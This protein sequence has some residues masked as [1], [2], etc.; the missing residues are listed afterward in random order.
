MASLLSV[1][2]TL[3]TSGLSPG[4][5]SVPQALPMLPAEML[6]KMPQARSAASAGW[7]ISLPPGPPHD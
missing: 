4:E 3:N 7:K 5:P 1:E 6:E 2:P